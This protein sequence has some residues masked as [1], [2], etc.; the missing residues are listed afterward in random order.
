MM[1]K[2]MDNIAYFR[3]LYDKA[4]HEISKRECAELLKRTAEEM[5]LVLQ[6]ERAV[7]G[8][9]GGKDSVVLQHLMG[10]VGKYV[11]VCVSTQL[12]Y[13]CVDAFISLNKPP[14]TEVIR[15]PHDLN[16]LI[17]NPRMLMPTDSRTKSEW[18]RIVQHHYTDA[19]AKRVGATM[20]VFGRRTEDGNVMR[21]KLYSVEGK[22]RRYN[23]LKDFTHVQI[24]GILRHFDLPE[25]P[26]YARHASSL[27]TGTGAW[28]QEPSWDIVKA[29]D[30][31]LYA[32]V[33]RFF[34]YVAA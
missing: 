4:H 25:Y 20:L 14:R 23:P 19:F 3:G 12:E 18:Y 5:A 1:L 24:W 29:T 10:M 15:T 26:L 33:R 16:W 31:A 7:Y 2:R 27:V 32:R 13:P 30:P 6:N 21:A 17:R 22:P 34:P 9:S 28:A 8:W 11:G